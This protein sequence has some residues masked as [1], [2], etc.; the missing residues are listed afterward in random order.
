[1]LQRDKP[2]CFDSV[3]RIYGASTTSGLSIA[4]RLA[5]RLPEKYRESHCTAVVLG[6][7]VAMNTTEAVW[8]WSANRPETGTVRA[9][10][11]RQMLETGAISEQVEENNVLHVHLP[12]WCFEQVSADSWITATR[13]ASC[14][15]T[16]NFPQGWNT[17]ACE[18]ERSLTHGGPDWDA[19]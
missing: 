8:R 18:N 17:V 9:C 14:R 6:F 12:A 13:H 5:S 2:A 11:L 7:C 1:M 3:E 16:G 15:R 19:K 10:S 4:S